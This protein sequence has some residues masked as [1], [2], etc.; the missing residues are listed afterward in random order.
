MLNSPTK[1]YLRPNGYRDTS[2]MHPAYNPDID[3]VYCYRDF[4]RAQEDIEHG[5]S[6][7]DIKGIL[8]NLPKLD[9]RSDTEFADDF[10]ALMC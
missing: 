6:Y 7:S 3:Y 8:E 4:E 5:V 10:A 1:A 9:E 2:F